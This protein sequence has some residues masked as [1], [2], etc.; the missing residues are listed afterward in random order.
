MS[1]LVHDKKLIEY[2]QEYGITCSYHEFKRFTVSAAVASNSNDMELDSSEGLIYV[3][4]GNFDAHVHSQNGFKETRN[5][6]IIF[7]Q[8][9]SN[10]WAMRKPN[11]RLKQELSKVT[12]KES[13]FKY[14]TGQ[15]NPPTP[16]SLCKY[17]I[18]PLK[19]LYRQIISLQK[20]QSTGNSFIKKFLSKDDCYDIK[21]Y[22][23]L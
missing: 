9:V 14:F 21:D 2:L 15:N 10:M 12:L 1:V 22:Y 3:E 8:P 13:E 6:E 23:N 16:G 18:L 5:L 11:P 17:Q 19:A 20:G 7:A 4:S